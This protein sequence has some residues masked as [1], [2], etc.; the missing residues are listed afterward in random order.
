MKSNLQNSF[1]DSCL[2]NIDP[3]NRKVLFET[4]FDFIKQESI[5]LPNMFIFVTQTQK[6]DKQD[7][8]NLLSVYI[9]NLNILQTSGLH[10]L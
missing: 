4:I 2:E 8:N 10:E 1:F 5:K 7:F 6:E 9:Q 3:N